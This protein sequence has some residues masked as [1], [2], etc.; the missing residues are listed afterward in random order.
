VATWSLATPTPAP[1][2]DIL[3]PTRDRL[4]LLR[5]CID[6]VRSITTYPNYRITVLDNDSKEPATLQYLAESGV[7]VVPCP[8][9]FNY[10]AIVNRGV[11]GTNGDVVITLNNDTTIETAD[12]LER[13][14]GLV[15]VTNVAVVGVN[16]SFPSGEWQHQGV[17]AVPFPQHIC[18][19]VNTPH[20]YPLLS[21]TR[22]VVAVTGACQAVRREVWQAIQGYDENLAVVQNDIDFCFRAL[23]AGYEIVV[24]AGIRLTHDESASRGSLNPIEDILGFLRRWDVLGDF[25]DPYFSPSV[26]LLGKTLYW[27]PLPVS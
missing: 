18:Q 6:S 21:A 13:L 5:A 16:L 26:E 2:V 27:Q 23:E 19:G 8:G 15:T 7:N 1:L 4:E 24:D 17:T 20:A 14:V 9:P 11:A 3:I 12:W 22:E 10:A 25:R